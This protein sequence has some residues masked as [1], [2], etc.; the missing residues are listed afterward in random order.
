MQFYEIIGDIELNCQQHYKINN[1]EDIFCAVGDLIRMSQDLEQQYKMLAEKLRIKTKGLNNKSLNTINKMLYNNNLIKKKD[2]DSL[3][4][5][6][7]VRNYINHWYF[8]NDFNRENDSQEQILNLVWFILCEGS[9]VVSNLI[10]KVEGSSI[11]R[12]TIFD[13]K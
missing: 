1:S 9:D 11:V 10:D 2:F 12:Q 8:L 6:I 7:N 13:K 5:V 3:H 4:Y